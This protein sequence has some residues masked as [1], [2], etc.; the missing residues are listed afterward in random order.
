M[1][2]MTLLTYIVIQPIFYSGSFHDF[3]KK[4]SILNS[5]NGLLSRKYKF[6]HS[7]FNRLNS[8]WLRNIKEN[9]KEHH[10]TFEN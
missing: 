8:H 9:Q 3:I 4:A 6:V 10:G 5:T 7:K 1:C 2:F